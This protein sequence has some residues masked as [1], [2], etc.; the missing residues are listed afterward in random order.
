VSGKEQS[1]REKRERGRKNVSGKGM[2]RE[3]K[4]GS[5]DRKT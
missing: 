3:K 5:G 1:G 2:E 4:G